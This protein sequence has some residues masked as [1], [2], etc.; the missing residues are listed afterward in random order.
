M[1]IVTTNDLTLGLRGRVGRIFVFRN[2]R[3]KT[4]ASRA[5]RKPDPRKQSPAQRQ[6]RVTFKDAAAWAVR[7]LL[8]P[9]QKRYFRERAKALALPNAYTAAVQDYLQRARAAKGVWEE[10][11]SR[12]FTRLDSDQYPKPNAYLNSKAEDWRF[13]TAFNHPRTQLYSSA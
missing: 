4:I 13:P 5:P 6:T 10:S 7:T 2:L 11:I 8:D 12:A 1:A 3:G 9:K